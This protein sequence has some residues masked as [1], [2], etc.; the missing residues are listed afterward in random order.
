MLRSEGRERRRGRSVKKES[1]SLRGEK[2]ER[3]ERRNKELR[4]LKIAPSLEETN[5]P[6]SSI[7][8]DTFTTETTTITAINAPPETSPSSSSSSTHL[9]IQSL[10]SILTIMPPPLL[11]SQDQD[12]AFFLLHNPNISSQ[13]SEPQLQLIVLRFLLIIV[14]LYL[15]RVP[16]KKLLTGFEAV[17]LAFYAHETTSRA[18]QAITVN[19]PD[20]SY[21][22]T[23]HEMK[24]QLAKDNNVAE[25]NLAVISLSLEPH[26]IVRSTRRAR[27]VGVAL[28]LLLVMRFGIGLP[29]R[30]GPGLFI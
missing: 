8:Q 20:L 30:D 24:D 6:T 12:P 18:G 13:S 27:I 5:T 29:M 15:S 25:F 11:S 17:L 4:F 21:S 23:Y 16:L 10:S 3:R 7:S 28:E 2:S 14:G 22:S 1:C 19:V 26:G 9:A